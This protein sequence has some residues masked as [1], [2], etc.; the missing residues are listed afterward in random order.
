MDPGER[1]T[2]AVSSRSQTPFAEELPRLLKERGV[3]LRAAAAQFGIDPGHL[4]KALRGRENKGATDALRAKV[5]EAF[6]LP[7]DYFPEDRVARI[8]A[9]LERDPQFRERVYRFLKR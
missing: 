1:H 3:S 6:D 8:V 9:R 7:E 2:A 4:S 5:R